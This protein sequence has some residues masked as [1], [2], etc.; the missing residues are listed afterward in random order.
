[1]SMPPIPLIMPKNK[2]GISSSR[3]EIL[4]QIE[5]NCKIKKQRDRN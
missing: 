3:E 5:K 4:N 1:M 2:F